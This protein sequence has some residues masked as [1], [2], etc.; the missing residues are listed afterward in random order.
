MHL[1]SGHDTHTALTQHQEE[2]FMAELYPT[3]DPEVHRTP[4]KDILLSV[5]GIIT[6]IS[7]SDEQRLHHLH[8]MLE[9]C[10][11]EHE[12]ETQAYQAAHRHLMENERDF[13][14]M[15]AV[16]KM[17]ENV[18]HIW[19]ASIDTDMKEDRSKMK[20]SRANANTLLKTMKHVEQQVRK[21]EKAFT[22]S[23]KNDRMLRESNRAI[24]QQMARLGFSTEAVD[25]EF[26][27]E[28]ER[29][30]PSIEN[31]QVRQSIEHG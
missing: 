29:L 18:F 7:L 14:A 11:V 9:L 12:R 8:H 31:G 27:E 21:A 10:A 5:K 24:E 25:R 30:F 28:I 3:P 26:Q 4:A 15:V 13:Q 2:A 23:A 20:C 22:S 6:D 16:P 17:P 19:E 1:R